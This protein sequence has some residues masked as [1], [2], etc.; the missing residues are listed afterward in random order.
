M[1]EEQTIAV[2]CMRIHDA[3]MTRETDGDFV[4]VD[5]VAVVDGSSCWKKQKDFCYSGALVVP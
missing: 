1:S 3:N 2:E 4:G 5:D